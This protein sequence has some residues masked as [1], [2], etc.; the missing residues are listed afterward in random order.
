[1]SP[2][3]STASG[4]GI[5]LQGWFSHGIPK[6]ICRCRRSQASSSFVSSCFRPSFVPVGYCSLSDNRGKIINT[7]INHFL[8]LLKGNLNISFKISLKLPKL[9][10]LFFSKLCL[11]FFHYAF[12]VYLFL[13]DTLISSFV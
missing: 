5:V 7:K 2:G 8:M 1:M 6:T 9:L 11:K 3:W 13:C 12:L 10:S 4:T